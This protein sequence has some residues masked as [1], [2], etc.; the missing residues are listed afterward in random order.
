MGPRPLG[1]GDVW[2]GVWHLQILWRL[3]WGRDLSAAETIAVHVMPSRAAAASMGPRPLGRGDGSARYSASLVVPAL[4]WGRDLSAAETAMGIVVAVAVAW[5]QWG[6]DL[7]AAE[8]PSV[9]TM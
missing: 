3:Q 6:R 8:T 5:L 4:Q 1:R 2:H 7:S 9:A